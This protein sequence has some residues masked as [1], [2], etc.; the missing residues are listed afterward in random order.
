M[1][2]QWERYHAYKLNLS[3]EIADAVNSEGWDAVP[4]G[5]AYMRLSF[6]KQDDEQLPM[7][8]MCA[9]LMGLYQHG[10]TVEADS[11]E[12]VFA[13]DNAPHSVKDVD[14]VYHCRGLRSLS[15]GDVVR[16]VSLEKKSLHVCCNFGWVELPEDVARAFSVM[17]QD[18]D[19][20]RPNALPEAA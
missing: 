2:Y 12:D 1:L 13:Y 10:L 7:K 14:P 11:L 16:C 6:A 9:A 5:S 3:D 17:A 20:Q 4:E 8:V 19:Y 18:I 15:V